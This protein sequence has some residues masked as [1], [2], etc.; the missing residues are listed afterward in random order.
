M[1]IDEA[2]IIYIYIQYIIAGQRE[3][4]MKPLKGRTSPIAPFLYSDVILY[5]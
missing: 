1:Q 2:D 5:A 4:A 3:K